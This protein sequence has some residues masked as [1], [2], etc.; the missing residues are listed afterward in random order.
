[1]I[2]FVL[3]RNPGYAT[4]SHQYRNFMR[5]A[6]KWAHVYV[7]GR[8]RIF[9]LPIYTY[10]MPCR[11]SP[12]N[13]LCNTGPIVARPKPTPSPRP[14]LFITFWCNKNNIEI[15]IMYVHVRRIYT[16]MTEN[17]YI[18]NVFQLSYDKKFFIKFFVFHRT[19][20]AL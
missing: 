1:M 14:L 10:Y 6:K 5:V 3:K 18:L 19:G 12:E 20:D 17:H 8:I 15:L 4:E 16:P 2:N 11:Y 7:F 9:I 13:T